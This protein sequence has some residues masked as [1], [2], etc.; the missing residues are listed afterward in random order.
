MN[1]SQT[2]DAADQLIPEEFIRLALEGCP[3]GI[4]I[5]DRSRKIVLVNAELERLFGYKREEL[6]GESIDLLVPPAVRA[7]HRAHRAGL[8]DDSEA[9][10]MQ[11]GREFYGMRKDGTEVPVEIGLSLL[12]T[13]DDVM[14]LSVITDITERKLADERLRLVIEACPSGMIMTTPDGDIVLVN[15]EA[16]RIFGYEREELFGQSVDVLVPAPV[17]AAHAHLR[18]HFSGQPEARRMGT[19]RDLHGLRKDGTQ[20]PVEIGFNPIRTNDGPMILIALSDITERKAAEKRLV[21]LQRRMVERAER[22]KRDA[23]VAT[24]RLELA[25]ME[26]EEF[27]YAASH[28]L[29]APLRVIDNASRW[30]EDDL[31]EHLTGEMRENMNLLRGRVGRME[32]LL[33]DLMEYARIRRPTEGEPAEIV[34]GDLLMTGVMSRLSVPEGFT[35]ETSP[36]FADA[37]VCRTPLQN[38]LLNLVDNAIKHHDKSGGRIEVTVQDCGPHHVFSV[39]DD[40]PGIPPQFH[41]QIFKVFQTL[42]PKD[43]VE[44]SGM[45]LAMVRK[46]IEVHGGTIELDSAEGSGSLFRFTWPKHPKSVRE[47]L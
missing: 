4:V 1:L 20:I 38:V 32:K 3:N 10:R 36:A 8:V 34:S 25:N 46:N 12:R 21:E 28:D 27:A 13:S 19:G 35:V 6:L 15:A 9:R 30:L 37:R 16:E 18:E 39:K 44:G 29:K 23:E 24:R 31:K 14:I 40:G 45:G 33:D 7:M 43:R 26:L 11:I 5:T 17:R 22:E 47:S 2:L 41:D 42:K